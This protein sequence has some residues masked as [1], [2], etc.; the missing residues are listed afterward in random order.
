MWCKPRTWGRSGQS[1][2][3]VIFK[4]PKDSVLWAKH[5]Y[6]YHILL[7]YLLAIILNR[8]LN[9]IHGT[10]F[11]PGSCKVPKIPVPSPDLTLLRPLLNTHTTDSSPESIQTH[12]TD[13]QCD[14]IN[15]MLRILLLSANINGE[16]T[17]LQCE[18]NQK[19]QPPGPFS[20]WNFLISHYCTKHTKMQQWMEGK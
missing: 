13:T 20:N 17:S 1:E 2:E 10:F 12:K 7:I 15:G 16:V 18:H 4:S 5:R 14:I 19:P 8:K 9:I 11:S 6:F 3:N